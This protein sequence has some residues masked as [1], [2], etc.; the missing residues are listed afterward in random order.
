M[1][2]PV[3]FSQ[4]YF[5]EDTRSISDYLAILGRRRKP[6]IIAFGLLVLM[7]IGLALNL[8]AVYRSTAVI[9]IEQQEIP[10]GLVESTVT[11][12]AD[13]RIQV[14]NQRV[15]TSANLLSLIKK[16]DLYV[17]ERKKL[18]P[19]QIIGMM[20]DNIKLEMISADVLDP[21]SGRPVSATI[22]FSLAFESE[23]PRKAQEVANELTTLYLNE[24]IHARRRSTTDTAEFLG[25]EANKLE[26]EITQ[27]E[28]KLADFKQKNQGSLPEQIDLNTR[29]MDRVERDLDS[30][31]RDL[32]SVGERDVFL[33]GELAVLDPTMPDP[34]QRGAE[35]FDADIRLQALQNRYLSALSKYS[36]NHPDVIK[37]RN[38][39]SAVGG[40]DGQGASSLLQGELV[41]ARSQLAQ[42]QERYSPAHPD[43]LAQQRRV[44]ALERSV[45]SSAS[46]G[47]PSR[48]RTRANP[49]FVQI[50]AQLQA[51]EVQ[52]QSLTAKRAQ[53][54]AR[55]T[56]VELRLDNT[57]RVE[58][59]Y[60]DLT[61]NHQ[62]A[63]SKYQEIKAKQLQARLAQSLEADNKGER[64]TLIEPPLRPE[65]PIKPNRPAIIVLGLLLA[66]GAG[67]GLAFILE[68]MD[69]SI[70]SRH[71]LMAVTGM[72]PLGVI[73][74]LVDLE[75]E[76]RKKKR[77]IIVVLLL[78]LILVSTL[79]AIVHVAYMPLDILMIRLSRVI[80]LRLG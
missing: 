77:N 51:N 25:S 69:S 79:L 74:K 2:K 19:E 3:D 39:I 8:P 70:T 15:M 36:D 21:R 5:E 24:N 10:Q 60:R 62:N 31:D 44:E 63:S 68:A 32:R 71:S 64:F 28:R 16:Y 42:Y 34:V 58:Q 13:Q 59:E 65:I 48:N 22:A 50:R 40:G 7:A 75:E 43:V 27:L 78:A 17:E 46:I 61:R 30:V 35:V 1:N 12:Y 73:P 52:R 54:E 29:M 56:K 80:E 47:I 18:P 38:E 14:I 41:T 57:P 23:S 26:R 55:M 72:A 37:L 6:A 20:R 11:G 4:E 67:L 66:M 49:A 9:L 76:A 53:L 33:R 45:T